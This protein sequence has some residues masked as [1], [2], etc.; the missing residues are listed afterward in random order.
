MTEGD[1]DQKLQA[2]KLQLELEGLALRER[3]VEKGPSMVVVMNGEA[4]MARLEQMRKEI[5][6]EPME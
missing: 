5:S 4:A 2:S 3:A 1:M 6:Y